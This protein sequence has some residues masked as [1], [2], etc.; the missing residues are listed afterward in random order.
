MPA[1]GGPDPDDPVRIR[2]GDRPADRGR[3]RVDGVGAGPQVAVAQADPFTLPTEVCGFPVLVE[4]VRN[5][6]YST[7]TENPDGSVTIRFTG[8]FSS[9]YTNLD[10]GASVTVKISG[11]GTLVLYPDGS[12]DLT[13]RGRNGIIYLPED[14]ERL[15]FPD[16]FIAVGR[17]TEH[18]APDGSFTSAHLDGTIQMDV[19]AEIG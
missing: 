8:F 17:F 18:M 13:V 3:P 11:P 6:E 5:E 2:G 9:R 7:T 15:G 16:L 19:C 12:F 10:T 1:E 14:A 4:P